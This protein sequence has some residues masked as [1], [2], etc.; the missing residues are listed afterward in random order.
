MPL[1]AHTYLSGNYIELGQDEE[2]GI[3]AEQAIK[4]DPNFSLKSLTRYISQYKNKE[5]YA[6]Y[7]ESL[8]KAGLPD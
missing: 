5:D 4:I 2:A 3:H 6:R 1:Y 8:R 7:I